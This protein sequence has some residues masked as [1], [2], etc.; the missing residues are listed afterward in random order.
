MATTVGIVDRIGGLFLLSHFLA[1]VKIHAILHCRLREEDAFLLHHLTMDLSHPGHGDFMLC[2]NLRKGQV[3][4][5]DVLLDVQN[6]LHLISF[7]IYY[8][9]ECNRTGGFGNHP[10]LVDRIGAV[11]ITTRG[12]HQGIVP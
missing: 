1:H 8:G 11:L 2:G 4:E 9:M 10:G 7:S 5:Q 12:D 3:T 6:K